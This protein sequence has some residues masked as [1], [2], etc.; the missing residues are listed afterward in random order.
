MLLKLGLG[1]VSTQ[2]PEVVNYKTFFCGTLACKILGELHMGGGNRSAT[3]GCH[4]MGF[5]VS[6]RSGNFSC[7]LLILET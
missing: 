5:V 3:F 6:C 7:F 4:R 1:R 2:G